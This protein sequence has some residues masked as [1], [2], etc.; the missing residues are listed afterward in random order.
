MIV[1]P[2]RWPAAF[3]TLVAIASLAAPIWYAARVAH[4]FGPF[5]TLIAWTC[6]SVAIFGI[7]TL[8]V[9][10]WKSR[11]VATLPREGPGEQGKV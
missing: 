8:L 4:T 10:V 2:S 7:L 3:V 11:L 5:G 1:P 9:S 6:V